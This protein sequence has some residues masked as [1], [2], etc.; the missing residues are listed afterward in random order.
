MLL[1]F[2]GLADVSG[3]CDPSYYCNNGS[4]RADPT[5]DVMGNVC[6]AGRFCG[7][8]DWCIFFSSKI[9]LINFV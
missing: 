1:Y 8:F 6:P 5:D 4:D 2:A 7:K 9:L 3:P